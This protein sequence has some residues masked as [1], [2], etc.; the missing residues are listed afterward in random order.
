MEIIMLTHDPSVTLGQDEA[1]RDSVRNF[2]GAFKECSH[3]IQQLIL[4]QMESINDPD[5]DEMDRQTATETVMEALFPCTHTDGRHGID[6]QE[7][8]DND[9]H[10][11]DGG[12]VL[13]EMDAEEELFAVRLASVMK[14]KGVSQV[15][16]AGRIGIG[17]PAV[18]LMLARKCRP[19]KRTI[20]KMAKALGVTSE[21]LWPTAQFRLG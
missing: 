17:Q 1:A 19:Q 12:A 3:D 16:L 14:D 2:I 21:D 18:S 6:L 7:S 8:E 4:R 5:M 10:V 11:S 9:R 15:E 20:E 13:A